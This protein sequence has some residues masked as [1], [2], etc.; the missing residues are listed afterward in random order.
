VGSVH[1][2]IEYRVGPF[3]LL[4]DAGVKTYGKPIADTY[5]PTFAAGEAMVIYPL[6][7]GF[8]YRF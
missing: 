8:C 2:G 6:R 4:V 1:V 5:D 7:F 3:S